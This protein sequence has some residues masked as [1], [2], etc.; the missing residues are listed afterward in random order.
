MQTR[1]T[2]HPGG[3]WRA[4]RREAPRALL[5]AAGRVQRRLAGAVSWRP[6][7]DAAALLPQPLILGVRQPLGGGG[8]AFGHLRAAWSWWEAAYVGG[9][10]RPARRPLARG[11]ACRVERPGAVAVPD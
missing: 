11:D 5:R 1:R 4:G 6:R 2:S 7:N 8:G 10:R 3:S 9:W